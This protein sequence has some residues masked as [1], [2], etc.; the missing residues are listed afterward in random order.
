MNNFRKVSKIY[1]F[2]P[3]RSANGKIRDGL[4]MM[5]FFVYCGLKSKA[6]SKG[7]VTISYDELATYLGVSK[8]GCQ[9]TIYILEKANLIKRQR[10]EYPTETPTYK[11]LS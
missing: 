7:L 4:G 5:P 11:V 1:E 8:S 6:D 3:K 9:K 10:P 2:V